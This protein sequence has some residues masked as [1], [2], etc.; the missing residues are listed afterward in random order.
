MISP[1][2]MAFLCSSLP[3]SCSIA[4][5]SDSDTD[6]SSR[7]SL[8]IPSWR[9]RLR[10]V[11]A[12]QICVP[13]IDRSTFVVSETV[14]EDELWAAASLRVRTF[15]EFNPSSY[16]IQVSS[17]FDFTFFFRKLKRRIRTK[18]LNC[19]SIVHLEVIEEMKT[20]VG[21]VSIS[22]KIYYGFLDWECSRNHCYCVSLVWSVSL[23]VFLVSAL[24]LCSL[25]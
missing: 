24:S 11:S 16:N 3:S 4:I 15:N 12:S 17:S 13:S 25:C 9:F 21:A 23:R 20:D 18:S 5:F 22:R 2:K 8:S 1:P 14:S 7:S 10:P 6:L 19:E